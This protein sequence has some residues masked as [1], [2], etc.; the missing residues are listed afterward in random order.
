MR[1]LTGAASDSQHLS[2]GSA[3][4]GCFS[5]SQDHKALAQGQ[6]T[7]IQHT[8]ITPR[9]H[10]ASVERRCI[11]GTHFTGNRQTDHGLSTLV[12]SSLVGL[13]KLP[14]G[15]SGGRGQLPFGIHPGEQGG[16][17]QIDTRFEDFISK[18]DGD[19]HLPDMMLCGNFSWQ[20]GICI[21][22][23]CERWHR[24]SLLSKHRSYLEVYRHQRPTW[25]GNGSR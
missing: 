5:G 20:A 12:K 21:G 15:W 19:R 10:I 14:W 25:S 23:N 18:V 11:C 16:V 8:D 9:E 22:N 24:V 3:C 7:S 17:V 13:G 2:F 6:A 4:F 1:P